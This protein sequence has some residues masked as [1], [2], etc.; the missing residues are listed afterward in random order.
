MSSKPK[1]KQRFV[2]DTTA[3][4]SIELRH[5]DETL[6]QAMERVLHMIGEAR[7]KLNIS[8][9]IPYPT[10]YNEMKQFIRR[11]GCDKSILVELDTWLVKKTPSRFEVKIP[12][13]VFYEYVKDMRE[14]MNR[15]MKVGE[16]CI[17]LSAA[18]AQ[19][20]SGKGFGKRRIDRESTGNII[21]D[22]RA[23][24]RNALR[25]GTLDSAPDLDVLLLAKEMEGGVVAADEGIK[26]WAEQLGLR[27]VY[28]ATF[29][30]M[31]E[32]YLKHTG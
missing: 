5:R 15:G 22:F 2:L 18:E 9:H 30:K 16:S 11:Y 27:F 32:E 13:E 10:V 6:C 1:E 3:L 20:L 8:C 21:K 28:G 12:S 17:R 4:T 7:M 26:K 23:K 25:Y 29:P 19:E 31:I 24:Y 14:R